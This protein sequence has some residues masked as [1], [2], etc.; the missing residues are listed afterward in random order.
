MS[1]SD[2][3]VAILS[4]AETELVRELDALFTGWA[5]ESGAAEII[6]PPLYPVADL[7]RLNVYESFPHLSFVASPLDVD[8]AGT[9]SPG[10]GFE[11]AALGRA[12][13]GLP[14][15]TCYGAYLYLAD[16]SVD[17]A[18]TITLINRCFRNETRYEGLRRLA[19]FQMREIVAVGTWEHTQD[20]LETFTGRIE[21]LAADL[22]LPLRKEAASDPF[23]QNDGARALFQKLSPVKYEFQYGDLAIASV[24]THRNFFGQRCAITL[25][26]TGDTAFTS[27]VAFGLERWVAAL[28]EVY[29]GDLAA[30]IQRVRESARIP[31]ASA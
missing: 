15:A 9:E 10:K 18:T 22:S 4:P 6:A 17:P 27:C 19:S 21:S 3:G 20:L 31:A 16:S 1:R 23:F 12:R 2:T 24:N 7:D 14:S 25:A 5:A 13:L 29:G 30:A 11:P 26:G 8:R 28:I